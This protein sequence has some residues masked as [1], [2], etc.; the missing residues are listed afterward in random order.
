MTSSKFVPF[1]AWMT[2]F[3]VIA[4]GGGSSSDQG[5]PEEDVPGD[6]I[7]ADA[8]DD[9]GQTEDSSPMDPG[10][11]PGRPDIPLDPGQDEVITDD[12]GTPDVEPTDPGGVDAED[13]GPQGDV[14][15]PFCP[16]V[17]DEFWF[18]GTDDQDYQG[19][20]CAECAICAPSSTCVGCTGTVACQQTS[21]FIQRKGKCAECLDCDVQDECDRLAF[22]D[23][24]KVCAEVDGQV[25]SYPDL[26]AL[27]TAAGCYGGYDEL[28]TAYGDCP[29]PTCEPCLGMDYNPVCGSNSKTYWNNCE[30]N[31]AG[32]CFGDTGVTRACFGACTTDTCTMCPST[33]APVCGDDNI[34]YMNECAATTCGTKAREVTYNGICC[35][36]CDSQPTDWTCTTAGNLYRHNCYAICHGETRCPDAGTPVCGLDGVDYVNA[37]E[38]TCRA[39]GVLH[40]GACVGLC[41]QCDG[42]LAPICAVDPDGK[43]RTYQNVCF[44]D[45]LGG[46]GGTA[47]LC[48]ANC[49]S[50]CG[51]L[52]SP[53]PWDPAGEVCAEDR[54]TYPS[55]CFPEKCLG[56]IAYTAGACAD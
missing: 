3:A 49:Q 5:W 10:Y 18:C 28:I 30:F 15:Q 37:C 11:D 12:D 13:P 53:K 8:P 47:G 50:I 46:T 36:E 51:T 7:Q 33:C 26:C 32:T 1:M 39:G 24:G 35:P 41:E 45:C 56:D 19:T 31:N 43:F 55:A 23:C 27:K 42:P 34:T 22:T 48:S 44:R 29:R 20:R 25:A 6:T 4:C 16:C 54:F 40:E 21:D 52:A 14:V 17:V 38:A 2:A 9:P